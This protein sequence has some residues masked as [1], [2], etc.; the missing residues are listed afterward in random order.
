MAT[1]S[2][3]KTENDTDTT[4]NETAS[5]DVDTKSDAANEDLAKGAPSDFAAG[6]NTR[7]EDLPIK[8]SDSGSSKASTADEQDGEDDD[9][10]EEADGDEHE[11]DDGDE[12]AAK[13]PAKPKAEAKADDKKPAAEDEDDDDEEDDDEEDDD[14]EDDD[15][16]EEPAP[17]PSAKPQAK[18]PAKATGSSPSGASKSTGKAAVA[19]KGGK[20]KPGAKG[21]QRRSGFSM[22][23]V[24]LFGGLVVALLAAFGMLGNRSGGTGPVNAPRWKTN[25]VVNVEITVVTTDYKDLGCAMEGDVA[26]RYCAF[27]APN[28]PNAAAKTSRD[29]DKLLQPFSTTDHVNFLASG[30]F[31]QPDIKKKLDAENWERPSPR[32]NANCK[33]KVEGRAKAAQVQWKQGDA[34]GPGNN[35]YTGVITE[36]KLGK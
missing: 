15:E 10:D 31:M 5:S 22:R 29:D 11:G 33:L 7:G 6:P 30:F 27:T 36:C 9:G 12:D 4:D 20:A 2:A 1:E 16:E 18:A 23:N 14:E 8:L 19:R 25:D 26:G 24:I 13:A 21:Q 17:K 34:W 35:W 3:D 28:K 32:F